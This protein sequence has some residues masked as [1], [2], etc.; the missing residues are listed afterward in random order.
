MEDQER[1][2]GAVRER[3]KEKRRRSKDKE[4]LTVMIFKEV[5][6]V[7]RFVISPRVVLLA[8][9]FFLLYIVA[10]IYITNK[11]FD[12]RRMNRMQADKIAKLSGELIK[13]AKSLERSKQ[14]IALL[15]DY[16]NEGKEESQEPEPPVSYT[17][18]PASKILDIDEIKVKR[19][20]STIN[21]S[22]RIVNRLS[23]GE[24]PIGGYIFVL[25]SVKYSDPPEVWAYPNTPLKDGLPVD[26]RK[27]LR[28]LIQRFKTIRSQ[29]TLSRSINE[30]LVLKIL[31]YNRDGILILRKVIEV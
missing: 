1:D 13:T 24:E 7:K 31:V 17:E 19:D 28:F 2:M 23:N 27:G 5:G 25:A 11:Y 6:K 9:V 29:H 15:D 12:T 4:L 10:T 18:S 22:F 3:E 26:Y 20:I 21:V 8:S 14:H 30:P 16:I